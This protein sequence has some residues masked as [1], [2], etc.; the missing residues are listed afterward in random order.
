MAKELHQMSNSDQVSAQEAIS[1]CRK[2]VG[3]LQPMLRDTW[4]EGDISGAQFLAG[5]IAE[6]GAVRGALEDMLN[7]SRAAAGV[8]AVNGKMRRKAL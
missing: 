1:C 5:F 2:L 6:C 8:K 4:A 7:E 3:F